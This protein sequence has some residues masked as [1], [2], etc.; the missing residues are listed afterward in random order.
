MVRHPREF[1]AK[2]QIFRKTLDKVHRRD[3]LNWQEL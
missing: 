2:H 3:D 1:P